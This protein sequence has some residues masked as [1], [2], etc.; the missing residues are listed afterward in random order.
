MTDQPARAEAQTRVQNNQYIRICSIQVLSA[1]LNAR[2]VH[3]ANFLDLMN[4]VNI[5]RNSIAY[6]ASWHCVA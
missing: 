4:E 5:M 3:T 6:L 2:T 1:N